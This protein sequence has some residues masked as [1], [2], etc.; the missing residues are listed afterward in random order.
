[1]KTLQKLLHRLPG[2]QVVRSLAATVRVRTVRGVYP[3]F[4]AA[5][6]AIPSRRLSGY[7]NPSSASMYLGKVGETRPS[8]YPVFFW[9]SPLLAPFTTIFDLGGSVGLSYFSFR[10]YLAFPPDLRW[11]VCD[12]PAVVER[13]KEVARKHD[14]THLDFTTRFEDCDGSDILLTCGTLQYLEPTLA[15]LLGPLPNKPRHLFINRVALSDRP[16]YYSVQDI[17]SA[18]CPYRIQ[19][20]AE[21]LSSLEALGYTLVDSWD[22]PETR[23]YMLSRPS[24]RLRAYSGIYLRLGSPAQPASG[25]QPPPSQAPVEPPH[26]DGASASVPGQGQSYEY[27]AKNSSVG[28]SPSYKTM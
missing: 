18:L 11:I 20:R 4:A 22:C 19:N 13:G 24:W 16:T 10:N 9:I 26:A 7:D 25:P 8:D 15:Q 12:V 1:M 17:V 2:S 28:S 14:G 6:A 23:L 3:T 21:L 5:Q 27:P